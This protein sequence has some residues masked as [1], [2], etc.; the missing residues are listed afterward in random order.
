MPKLLDLL[1][2]NSA[3]FQ[4]NPKDL[5][6]LIKKIDSTSH[7]PTTPKHS[8]RML[9]FVTLP[10]IVPFINEQLKTY[11]IQ[12]NEFQPAASGFVWY[13]I[14]STW[15]CFA[16]LL[17]ADEI[18][19]TVE[20][21]WERLRV[22]KHA[23]ISLIHRLLKLCKNPV[24]QTIEQEVN[25]Y[26]EQQ[27]PQTKVYQWLNSLKVVPPTSFNWE[28]SIRLK[29]AENPQ[30]PI[31]EQ[32]ILNIRAHAPKG[33]GESFDIQL[34]D[35]AYKIQESWNDFSARNYILYKTQKVPLPEVPSLANLKEFIKTLE[36]IFNL[37]FDKTFD[38]QYFTKGFKQK[39]NIQKW[40]LKA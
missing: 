38:F 11:F 31:A 18:Q 34:K 6:K 30:A 16:L 10:A 23:D 1:T 27:N 12:E 9:S 32:L 29:T 36:E 8:Q 21:M 33:N 14:K 28:L 37:K 19:S 7:A 22:A 20:F 40:F 5:N 25:Q 17:Y 26:F 35:K 4:G 24:Y 13:D 3:T 2:Q 39:N 15:Y